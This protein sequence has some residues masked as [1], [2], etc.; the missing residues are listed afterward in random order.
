MQIPIPTDTTLEELLE[1]LETE[2][3]KD[4]SRY[5]TRRELEEL[6]GLSQVKVYKLLYA[7]NKRGMLRRKR[8]LR[9]NIAG[10]RQ[11]P[12]A[13]MFVQQPQLEGESTP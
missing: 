1:L 4:N 6:T 7:A 8:V 13:Y 9:V 5:H 3:T 2:E 10:E 12:P 11:R